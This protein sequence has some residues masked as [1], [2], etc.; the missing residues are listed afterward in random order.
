MS[1]NFYC[2]AVALGTC[3]A[4]TLAVKEGLCWDCW[5]FHVDLRDRLWVDPS[6]Q[7]KIM[8]DAET[9][10]I[11]AGWEAQWMAERDGVEVPVRKVFRLKSKKH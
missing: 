4:K 10:C 5:G 9:L 2:S 11:L 3:P 7:V 8:L 1:N 6:V